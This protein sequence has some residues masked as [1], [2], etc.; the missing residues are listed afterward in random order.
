MQEH[1]AQDQAEPWQG[2]SHPHQPAPGSHRMALA[3]Q[4]RPWGERAE[5]SW[6]ATARL[7]PAREE[8]LGH[9]VTLGAGGARVRP[10]L[11]S[12][13]PPERPARSLSVPAQGPVPAPALRTPLYCSCT[14]HPG[15]RTK[16]T[17]PARCLPALPAQ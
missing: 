3:L 4:E 15:P 17:T 10:L 6:P 14:P 13:W 2:L 9:W 7:S 8:R 11:P 1:G 12:L 5:A 16:I